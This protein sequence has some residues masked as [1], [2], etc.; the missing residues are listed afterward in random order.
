M[1]NNKVYNYGQYMYVDFKARSLRSLEHRHIKYKLTRY[2]IMLPTKSE[3]EST[4]WKCVDLK[5][6]TYLKL[7]ISSGNLRFLYTFT[8]KWTYETIFFF[9][10]HVMLFW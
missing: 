1:Y 7:S 9:G 10:R 5:I 3:T 4:I 2:I 8:H 6:E